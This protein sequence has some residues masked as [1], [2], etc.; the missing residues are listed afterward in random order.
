MSSQRIEEKSKPMSLFS[1]PLSFRLPFFFNRKRRKPLR[2]NRAEPVSNH[3]SMKKCLGLV[4]L[5]QITVIMLDGV[6]FF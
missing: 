5:A 3:R 1:Y 4:I 6:I 2:R